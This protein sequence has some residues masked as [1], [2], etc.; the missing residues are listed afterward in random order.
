MF[1]HDPTYFTTV[2]MENFPHLCPSFTSNINLLQGYNALKLDSQSSLVTQ[3]YT[4]TASTCMAMQLLLYIR[5]S[6]CSIPHLPL[7][8]AVL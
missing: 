1:Q 6:Q 4:R 2:S 8:T 5:P 3:I 7:E